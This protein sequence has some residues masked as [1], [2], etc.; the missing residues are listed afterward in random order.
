[1]AHSL[2]LDVVAEGVEA[3]GQ[4]AFLVERGCDEYQ[5]FL[6]SRAVPA[7]E[8]VRFLRRDAATADVHSGGGG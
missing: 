1:M 5:G 8:F 2:G 6:F 4:E 3:P 7:D